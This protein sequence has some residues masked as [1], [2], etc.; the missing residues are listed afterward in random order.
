VALT[1]KQIE[2]AKPREKPYGLKDEK[3]LY[4]QVTPQGSKLWRFR[5]WLD[6]KEN[7]IS[8]GSYPEITLAEARE[9]RD[10]LRKQI[11]HKVDPARAKK[12]ETEARR[13]TFSAVS[14]E[15]FEKFSTVWA[16]THAETI[17][18]RLD[19]YI[20]PDIGHM[21]IAT[22]RA[23]DI[24][25]VLRKIEAQGHGET[26]KRVR[27]ICGQVLRFAI[28]SG[29]A[30][31]DVTAGLRGALA[32][33]K[34]GNFAAITDPNAFGGLL[35]AIEDYDGFFVTK[36]ALRLAPLLFV[37]PGELRAMEWTELDL[38]KAVWNIPAEKMKTRRPHLVP[39]SIQAVKILHETQE[40]T[41]T[42]QY[43]F[44]SARS[45]KRPMSEN[46]ITAAL[47]RMGYLGQEMTGHGFRA[48]ASTLLY[49]KGYS[50]DVIERQ[51]AHAQSNQVKAAY[52]RAE[53]VPERV[54]MMQEWSNF[55]DE[56]KQQGKVLELARKA[57]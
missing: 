54:R 18:A 15:W 57:A 50:S 36:Q 7:R 17:R 3:G 22:I 8:L 44:P 12:E 2:A 32:P 46:A 45:W 1:V 38:E 9:K 40:L 52:C 28:A 20:L 29:L 48:S 5:Y 34:R 41:G 47:R 33:V 30:E 14:K 51:L 56:L 35:R 4:L 27:L 23:P 39:L 53:F 26:A 55:C 11:A 13:N 31:H 16:A 25:S 49:E 21:P 10:E 43:V 42:S 24:L 19:R 37:R 6:K